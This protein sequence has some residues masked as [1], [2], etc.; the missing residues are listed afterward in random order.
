MKKMMLMMCVTV[1]AIFLSVSMAAAAEVCQG[2]CL[3][4]NQDQK[5]IT[6]E[7]YD[8]NFDKDNPY[9]QSTGVVSD[10]N[11]ER[12]VIGIMPVPGDVLRIAYEVKGT[13]RVALRVMNVSKQDLRKK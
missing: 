4:Y 12:A 5:T 3:S 2:K 6:V 13:E 11:V 7:E 10:Y 1:L 8:T 9:G